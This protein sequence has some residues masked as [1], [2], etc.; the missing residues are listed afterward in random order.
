MIQD[1][2]PSPRRPPEHI[3][4]DGC[5]ELIVHLADPFSRRVAGR[6]RRQPKAFLAGTLSRP[7]ALKAGTRVRTFGIRFRP[8]AF[9]A[10][11]PVSMRPLADREVPLEDVMP[12]ALARDLVARLTAARITAGCFRAG[13][14]WLAARAAEPGARPSSP[15]RRAV[16]LVLRGRGQE[17]IEAIARTL[18]VSRRS[19]ERAFARDLGIRPKLY[20]RIVRLNAALATLGADDRVRAVDAALDA[21]YFDQAH[22]SR[23]FRAVA[24]RTASG[25]RRAGGELSRQLTRPERLLVMLA[26]E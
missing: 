26:G 10:L 19:L 16:A 6:W 22:L 23:D 7:W 21:G 4:P 11:F 1:M 24:G 9:P 3:V 5:P 13:E 25:G 12:A 14:A 8:G 15:A 18:G 20:A 17:R 2:K